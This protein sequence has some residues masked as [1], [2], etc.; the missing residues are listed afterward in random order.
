MFA[1]SSIIR[2]KY[3]KKPSMSVSLSIALLYPPGTEKDAK[4]W[5]MY[6]EGPEVEY[7]VTIR[8]PKEEKIQPEENQADA[9]SFDFAMDLE[10]FE[11]VADAR[12]NTLEVDVSSVSVHIVKAVRILTEPHSVDWFAYTEPDKDVF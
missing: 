6:N 10:E 9:A 8:S 11:T 7:Q 4:T 3:S 1:E 5:Q 12:E 2:P